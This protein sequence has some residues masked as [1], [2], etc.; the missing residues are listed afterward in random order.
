MCG[1]GRIEDVYA[2]CTIGRPERSR[3][4]FGGEARTTHP[5]DYDVFDALSL[6][7]VCDLHEVIG[8][9]EHFVDDLE[10]A[11]AAR[12]AL[13]ILRVLRPKRCVV[14]PHAAHEA[15]RAKF[16][17]GCLERCLVLAERQ[18]H[19]R[20]SRSE[21][22]ATSVLQGRHQAIERVD[23]GSDTLA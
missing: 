18:T 9:I 1:H 22:R 21:D 19:G 12:D 7:V 8:M 17:E 20:G 11:H 2:R 3:E 6:D 4:D 5:E 23:E 14:M 13:E 15:A 10:P 16:L